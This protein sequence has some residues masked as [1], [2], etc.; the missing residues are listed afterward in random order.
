MNENVQTVIGGVIIIIGFAGAWLIGWLASYWKAKRDEINTFIEANKVDG[1]IRWQD[2]LLDKALN[3][4]D[5]V[6]ASLNNK[7]KKELTD[8]TSDG[9]L[10]KED[11]KRL[12]NKAVELVLKELPDNIWE[13]IGLMEN[14]AVEWI[15]T[16]IEN[17]VQAQKEV[18]IDYDEIIETDDPEVF[19]ELKEYPAVN[20]HIVPD[21][22]SEN[23]DT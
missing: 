18:E 16:A 3:V 11:A 7:F 23:T 20:T 10:T 19:T 5:D 4:V 22:V 1:K 17:S 21:D 13:E 14:D 6:V 15:K 2:Y 8:A 9:K 12:R